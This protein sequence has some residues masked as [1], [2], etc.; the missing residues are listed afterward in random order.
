MKAIFLPL[1]LFWAICY[2]M[3]KYSQYLELKYK[4]DR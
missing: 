1:L 4:T 3:S 2:A